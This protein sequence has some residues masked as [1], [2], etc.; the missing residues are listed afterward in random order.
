[1][2]LILGGDEAGRNPTIEPADDVF[3]IATQEF[4]D[5]FLIL[6]LNGQDVDKGW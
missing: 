1:V 4:D 3:G 5:L 6:R 2:A